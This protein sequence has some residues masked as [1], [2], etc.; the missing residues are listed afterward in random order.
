M[1]VYKVSV[2]DGI[3]NVQQSLCISADGFT[4]SLAMCGYAVKQLEATGDGNW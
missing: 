2:I 1:T 4:W 3:P